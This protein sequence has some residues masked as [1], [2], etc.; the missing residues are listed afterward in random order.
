MLHPKIG[1]GSI[2]YGRSKHLE[3]WRTQ[4]LKYLPKNYQLSIYID[5]PRRGVAY[6][7]NQNLKELKDC[8]YIFLMDDDCFAIKEGWAEYFIEQSK[9]SGQHHFLYLNKEVNGIGGIHKTE[10][11]CTFGEVKSYNS[12]NGCF[13]FMTKEVLEKVGAFGTYTNFY[14]FEHSAYTKRVFLSG[15]NSFGENLCPSRASEFI[16]CM[17]IDKWG[18]WNTL[19]DHSTSIKPTEIETYLKEG[20]K[21]YNEDVKTI[22]KPIE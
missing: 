18:E 20:I 2:S 16:Y 5:E 17:D 21:N 8:H 11:E 15:L 14:G 12:S 22:F 1:I 3:F 19:V 9:I 4:M 7:K 13:M 6:G 10:D